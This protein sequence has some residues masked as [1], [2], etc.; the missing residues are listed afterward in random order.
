MAGMPDG[1][2]NN[3]VGKRNAPL[4]DHQTETK[5]KALELLN[6]LKR[7]AQFTEELIEENE[8]LRFR[9]VQMESENQALAR[10]VMASHSFDELL[11]K[12][13]AMEEEKSSLLNRFEEVESENKD[14]KERYN[15]IEEENNRLANLYIASFQL[16]STHDIKE[17]V[18]ISFEILINLVGTRDFA[19]YFKQDGQLLPVMSEGRDIKNLPL[20]RIGKGVAGRSAHDG[21][22]A[23]SSN[24]MA[25]ASIRHP[26]VCIPLQVASGLVGMFVIYSFL[27]QKSS[28]TELDR[29]LFKLLG[30]HAAM[31]LYSARLHAVAHRSL[32][33]A[34][35]YIQLLNS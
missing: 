25:E 26:K 8:R 21:S 16:H 20:I 19:L 18:R 4:L 22:L 13:N 33:E 28:I 10:Q 31:A 34:S 3:M 17:V 2:Y 1:G 32:E 30:G 23:L 11:V 27:A 7:G 9:L 5:T 35:S 6:V 15:E 14:Y 24:Q 12:I 29:E